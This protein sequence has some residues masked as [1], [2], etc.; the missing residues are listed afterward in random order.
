[1]PV[2]TS[3]LFVRYYLLNDESKGEDDLKKDKA[4]AYDYCMVI[5]V[6]SNEKVEKARSEDN[7]KSFL[8]S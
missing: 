6:P 1:M 5:P 3:V 8:N 4:S 2:A 7:S